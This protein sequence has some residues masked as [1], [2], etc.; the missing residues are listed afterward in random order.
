MIE[1]W[2]SPTPVNEDFLRRERQD[3]AAIPLRVWLAVLDQGLSAQTDYAELQSRLSRLKAPTLLIWGS[4]D[5]IMDV[6]LRQTLRA[7][8][9]AAQVKIFKGLGHNPM[10]EKP[11]L[12]ATTVQAFLDEPDATKRSP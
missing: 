5:P 7:A 3:A 6:S 11:E 8:L 10:W 1:W 2:S 4:E 12:V 9:P